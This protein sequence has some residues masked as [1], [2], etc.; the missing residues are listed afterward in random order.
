MYYLFHCILVKQPADDFEIS[1]FFPL[2]SI[3]MKSFSVKINFYEFHLR[4]VKFDNLVK[5]VWAVYTGQHVQVREQLDE[6]LFSLCILGGISDRKGQLFTTRN[7]L[8][9]VEMLQPQ[10]K[11]FLINF[12]GVF[13]AG[14]LVF[15]V[16]F[17]ITTPLNILSSGSDQ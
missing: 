11:P 15:S 4:P 8:M 6:V 9:L 1:K 2:Q 5:I 12:S 10:V 13:A 14:D 3:A 7:C 16:Q 17:Y